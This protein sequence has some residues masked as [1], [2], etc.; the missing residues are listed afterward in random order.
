MEQPATSSPYPA[1]LLRLARA[2]REES[3]RACARSAQL[4]ARALLAQE[5]ARSEL[6]KVAAAR[7]ERIRLRPA[8]IIGPP[9][10][11]RVE[12]IVPL[13]LTPRMLREIAAEFRELAE[14]AAAPEVSLAFHGLAFRY[15]ALAGG[16]DTRAFGSDRLH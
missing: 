7:A 11:G 1:P 15:T 10:R 5:A 12:A 6:G 9:P 2:V 8:V 16:W 3:A 13:P 4:I 14:Q